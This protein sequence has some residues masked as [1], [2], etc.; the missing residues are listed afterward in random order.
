VRTED[1]LRAALA[2]LERQA[3]AADRVLPGTARRTSHRLRSLRAI[4]WVAGIATTAALAGV[5]TALIL[6]GRTY[7][8]TQ[9]GGGTSQAPIAKTTLQAKVLAAFSAVGDE[10]VFMQGTYQTV[11]VAHTDSNPATDD[12]WYYPG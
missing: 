11:G 12:T 6:P 1:D 5:V 3:P 4:R 10:I 7:R 8:T 2:S 9:N